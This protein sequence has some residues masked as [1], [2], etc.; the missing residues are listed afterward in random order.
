MFNEPP[1]NF[2][3]SSVRFNDTHDIYISLA[4]GLYDSMNQHLDERPGT[5]LPA[6][7]RVPC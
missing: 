6:L 4:D 3:E 5:R 2:N 7:G 1:A